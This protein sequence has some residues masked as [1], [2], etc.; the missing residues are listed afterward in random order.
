MGVPHDHREC[1]V[2]GQLCH[3]P[4]IYPGHFESTCK[5]MA[6]AMPGVALDFRL[7]ESAANQPRDPWSDSAVRTEGKT[8]IAFPLLTRPCSSLRAAT[9]IELIQ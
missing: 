6:V 4:Q 7:F 1:P 8:G 2:P 3:R 9:A 5:G